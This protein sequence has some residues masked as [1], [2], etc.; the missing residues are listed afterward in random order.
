VGGT[1]KEL[2]DFR[3]NERKRITELVKS[4]GVDVTK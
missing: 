1:R 2:D 4:S 3:R